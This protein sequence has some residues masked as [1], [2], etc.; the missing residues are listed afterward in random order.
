M[1]KPLLTDESLREFVTELRIK[2]P[3]D[4]ASVDYLEYVIIKAFENFRGLDS[5]DL[6]ISNTIQ[7]PELVSRNIFDENKLEEKDNAN[8]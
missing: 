7:Y 1:E 2:N 8:S 6:L 3:S 4:H 5:N